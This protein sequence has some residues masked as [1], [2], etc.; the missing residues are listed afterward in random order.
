MSENLIIVFVKNITLGKVKTR[1]AKT[2][3][4]NAAFDVYKYLFNITQCESLKAKNCDLHVYFSDAIIDSAWPNT[5]KFIQSGKDL[6]ERMMNAFEDE[7]TRGYKR[8][9][10]VGSDLP[11]LSAKIMESALKALE[12]NDTVFGPS[13]DGGYYLIGM[14]QSTL[15]V[16]KDKPWSTSQLLEVTTKELEEKGYSTTQ[17][18]KLNDI[19]DI[20]DLKRSSI[21]EVFQYVFELK[22]PH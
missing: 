13:E 5:E 2:I 17:L 12:S 7:F 3:G 1:L 21:S 10:G 22:N 15:C 19:D 8:I 11:D 9:I 18:L 6:G 16:F 4:D 14:R 20:D